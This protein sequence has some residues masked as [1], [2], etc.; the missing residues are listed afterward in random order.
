[1]SRTKNMPQRLFIALFLVGAHC[2]ALASGQTSRS[3]QDIAPAFQL[4]DSGIKTAG[5][6]ENWSE[7]YRLGV[8][9]AP[10]GY[11]VSKVE[12]WLTGDRACGQGAECRELVRSDRQVVW[13]FRLRGDDTHSGG[14]AEGHIRVTYRR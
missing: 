9:R 2:A 3:W 6:G 14:H 8:G 4:A 11:T 1:M 7:W 13:E 12:F 10:N 5:A